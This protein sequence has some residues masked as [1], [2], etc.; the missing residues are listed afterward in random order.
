MAKMVS[1]V[2]RE[3]GKSGFYLN[4]ENELLSFFLG[5]RERKRDGLSFFFLS[6]TLVLS[7]G[8]WSKSNSQGNH[9]GIY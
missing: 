7:N 9:V 1:L 6:P 4:S 2:V 8:L 5:S 3:V